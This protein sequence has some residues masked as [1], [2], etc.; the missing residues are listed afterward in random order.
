MRGRG[1]GRGDGCG[2]RDDGRDGRGD[3]G[4]RGGSNGEYNDGGT[5]PETVEHLEEERLLI[6]PRMVKIT[7]TTIFWSK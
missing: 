1:G 7:T 2:G 3:R 5:I 6:S 4:G